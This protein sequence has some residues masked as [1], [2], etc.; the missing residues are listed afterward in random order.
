MTDQP[1]LY[2]AYT[3][4]ERENSASPFWLNIGSAFAH[5]DGK[6]FNVILQAL[7]INTGKVVLR[8][9]EEQPPQSTEKI[10]VPVKKKPEQA[11]EQA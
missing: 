3:V 9:Y 6:G 5:K 7:P 1:P 11:P 2:R 10:V 4:I 8:L